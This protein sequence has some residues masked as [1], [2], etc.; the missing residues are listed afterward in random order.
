M[1]TH[2]L[3]EQLRFTRMEW[4]RALDGVSAKDALVHHG[5]M[6]SIGWIV[7][8]LTWQEQRYLL[9]RPQGLKPRPDIQ[10]R[11]TTGGKMS[12]PE[13]AETLAAWHEITTAAEPFLAT[14]TTPRLLRDLPLPKGKRSGQSQGSAIRRLI[15]HYW[16]HIGEI[17]AIRQM[18]RQ[19]RLPQYV[20]ALEQYAPY[21]P[22]RAQPARAKT[23]ASTR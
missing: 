20:G 6:N 4:L 14:L 7:G 10:K 13:L 5:Q 23:V 9:I 8:H 21:R 22:D 11:F 18:L 3:V 1:K 12:T 16:F 2:P 15:F 19:K 17:M